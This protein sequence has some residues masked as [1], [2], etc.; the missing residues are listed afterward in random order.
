MPES[1][2]IPKVI[3]LF[4]LVLILCALEVGC[5]NPFSPSVIGPSVLK[6]I[7]PQVNPDSVLYNFKYAYENRDSVVYE[8]C[9]DE[10][11]VFTYWDQSDVQGIFETELLRSEDIRVTK[12]LFRFFDEITLH[13]W[14]VEQAPDSIGE[15]TWKARIVS[16]DLLVWDT[17]G[18]YNYQYLQAS[19][20]AKFLFRQSKKDNLW[21]IVRWI[22][23]TM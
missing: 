7:A 9:L 3:G 19:G 12:A 11:F 16:Y 15:E 22:D 6:P 1:S 13:E 18:D 10:D 8:N 2:E 21:R 20:Y 5:F 4:L 17:D 23:L 14:K